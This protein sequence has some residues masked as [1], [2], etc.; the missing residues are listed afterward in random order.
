MDNELIINADTTEINISLL[1]NKKLIELH[2]EK[3]DKKVSV[4]DIYLGKVK[5]LAPGLNAAFIDI[6]FDK[7]AFLHYHDLGA[8]F[9]T[10]NKFV[11]RCIKNK[12]NTANLKNFYFEKELDKNGKIENVLQSEDTIMVQV[13]KEAISTKG[14]RLSSE[15]TLAGRYLVLVPFSN[16][17]SI[18]QKIKNKEEKDRIKALLKSIMPENFGVIAR[19]VSEG[20]SVSELHND[21]NYLLNKWKIVYNNLKNSKAPKKILGELNRISAFL[22]D[23]L[24]ESYSRIIINNPFLYQEIKAFVKSIAPGKEKI[25]KLYKGKSPIFQHFGVDKQIKESFGKIVTLKSG[26]YLIIEHTEAMHVIDVNSGPKKAKGK[27][28]EST[29][30][31]VNLEAATEVARQLRLRDLG[32]IIVV[33]FIDLKEEKN[34][35]ILYKHLQEAMK[36]DKARHTIL[37]PSKFGLIEITRQR[38]RPPIQIETEEKCICC[39]GSGKMEASILLIDKIEIALNNIIDENKIHGNII[40]YVHPFIDAYLKRGIISIKNLWI[41]KYKRIIKIIAMD[42]FPITKFEISDSKGKIVY[43]SI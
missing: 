9:P 31:E 12:Q 15:I 25:V 3:A 16:R 6:G 42:S 2:K 30:L 10:M 18:S 32:G 39:G 43:S 4:G 5:K 21:L 7:D 14:P 37:A 17:I 35:N 1:K 40:I 13:A 33:D 34:R 28:Q 26:I 41:K 8:N 11:Y 27:D 19:T 22:R 29:A 24:N 20:K 36:D 23:M 38:V